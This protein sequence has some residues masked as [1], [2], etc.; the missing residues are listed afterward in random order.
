MIEKLSK[1]KDYQFAIITNIFIFF[2]YFS[3]SSLTPYQADDFRYKINPLA[4]DF[5]LDLI[6]DV[7]QFQI[8]HYYNWSGRIIGHLILQ[9]FLIPKKILFDLVNAVIQTILINI[10]FYLA[11]KNIAKSKK[12]VSV[13]LIINI[14]LF[15]G[16]YNYTSM[17]MY[18][19]PTI[20]YTWMH[21]LVLI[22]YSFFLKLYNKDVTK[23]V[24]VSFFIV[25][26]FAGSTN[27]HVFIAQIAFYLIIYI[28]HIL[29]YPDGIPKYFI[30]SFCGVF[31]GGAVLML[32]PGNFVRA[33]SFSET[34]N[35]S[36]IINYIKFDLMWVIFFLK[37]VW[38]IAIPSVFIYY[39]T[40]G[41]KLIINPHSKLILVTGII[42][43]LSL[44][45]SP[46]YHNGTNLFF[47]YCLI[48]FLISLIEFK[49]VKILNFPLIILC[50]IILQLYLISSQLGIYKYDIEIKN[51]I[52]QR[53]NNGETDIIINSIPLDVNRLINYQQITSNPDAPRNQH[54]ASYYGINTIRTN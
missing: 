39:I 19:T 40:N 49:K 34:I 30:Y 18:V 41:K 47:F 37:P 3:L 54:M 12:D 26:L 35:I 22:Y 48:I 4:T 15:L 50:S 21:V 6:K 27:E 13:L 2:F 46:S 43:S 5:K 36:H 38:F 23:R 29:R 24:K 17:T 32:A 45:C 25:G 42:S 1:L 51:E 53:K 9:L 7:F 28:Y 44:A 8:W 11:K 10:I 52:L 16:F 20:V 33:G 31:I 14:L